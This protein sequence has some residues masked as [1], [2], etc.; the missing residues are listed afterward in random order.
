[1]TEKPYTNADIETVGA[2]IR[3]SGMKN[4]FLDDS[5]GSWEVEEKQWQYDDAASAVLDALA[6]AGRLAPVDDDPR[7]II[8]L[9]AD[10]WTIMHPLACRPQL[11]E[12]PVNRAA[13]KHLFGPPAELGRYECWADGRL[14][15]ISAGEFLVGGRVDQAEEP[16]NEP[17]DADDV[18][19]LLDDATR[20]FADATTSGERVEVIRDLLDGWYGAWPTSAVTD[21]HE[22]IAHQ[23]VA[24]VHAAEA[25]AGEHVTNLTE[26]RNT[27]RAQLDAMTRARDIFALQVNQACADRDDLRRRLKALDH[28]ANAQA[29]Q[30]Y[31]I[32]R[33]VNRLHGDGMATIWVEELRRALAGRPP[34][35]RLARFV[36]NPLNH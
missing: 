17:A 7:H 33:I 19:Q 24:L 5:T 26:Q 18:H 3:E 29:N 11:F 30:L 1:M 13:E 35:L 14:D 12:C 28:A 23:I 34:A 27:L 31:E 2:A 32:G 10:G 4:A 6:A 9:R 20:A 21:P 15:D 16:Q 25:R 8:D 22:G 36:A